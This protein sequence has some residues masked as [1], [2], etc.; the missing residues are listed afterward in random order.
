M[1]GPVYEETEAQQTVRVRGVLDELWRT[2][3]DVYI[4]V[5]AH[6]GTVKGILRNFGHREFRLQTGGMIPVVVRGVY[7]VTLLP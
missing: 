1:W 4:S 5:T 7:E 2:E 6:G 3:G